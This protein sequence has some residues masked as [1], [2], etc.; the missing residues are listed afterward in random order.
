[1][2]AKKIIRFEILFIRRWWK[3]RHNTGGIG[4]Q[5]I[6]HAIAEIKKWRKQL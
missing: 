6:R 5:V 3:I 1:M 4:N 2:L